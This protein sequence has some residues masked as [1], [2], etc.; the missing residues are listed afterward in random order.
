VGTFFV[1]AQAELA[2]EVAAS[3]QQNSELTASVLRGVGRRLWLGVAGHARL[4]LDDGRDDGGEV[5]WQAEGGPVASLAVGDYWLLVH[6]G[7]LSRTTLVETR[8]GAFSVASIAGW[9]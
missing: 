8:S 5:R 7:Y 6:G 4:D 1:F 3:D 2:R 9:F